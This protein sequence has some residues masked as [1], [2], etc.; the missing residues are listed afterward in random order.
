MKKKILFS[1]IGAVVIFVWQFLSWAM[2]NL[3]SPASRY[4]PLQGEILQKLQ[5][6]NLPEG[7]YMLGQPDPTKSHDEMEKE[8]K[9]NEH[10]P[11]AVINYRTDNSMDM[12]MPMIRGFIVDIVIAFLLFWLFLQQKDPTLQNRLFLALAVGFL[13][14]LFAPYTNYIWYK[15]P[16]IWAHLLDAIVPWSILGLIGHKMAKE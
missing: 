16:D 15:E 2:P 3:H 7:M 11:W 6:L 14:F 8:M 5:E 10:K 4:T 1:L 9:A 13:C 12:V